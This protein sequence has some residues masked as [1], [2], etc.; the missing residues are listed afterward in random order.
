MAGGSEKYKHLINVLHSFT[1]TYS[2]S[3]TKDGHQLTD[4]EHTEG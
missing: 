4:D 3:D 2:Y 1:M